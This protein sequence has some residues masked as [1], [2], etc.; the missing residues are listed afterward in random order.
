MKEKKQVIG[1]KRG[2][3]SNWVLVVDKGIKHI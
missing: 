1:Y 3:K 2:Y